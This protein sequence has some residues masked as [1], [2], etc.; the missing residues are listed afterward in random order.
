VI[1]AILAFLLWRP[2]GG[3]SLCDPLTIRPHHSG[4][5]RLFWD[6]YRLDIYLVSDPFHVEVFAP[7]NRS[8]GGLGY[9]RASRPIASTPSFPHLIH[10][11]LTTYVSETWFVRATLLIRDDA[12]SVWGYTVT[13]DCI[14]RILSEASSRTHVSYSKILEL[15]RILRSQP[16]PVIAQH[17]A[18][19]P[20]EFVAHSGFLLRKRVLWAAREEASE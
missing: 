17:G 5:R 12:V 13:R 19:I 1:R 2:N 9:L 15:E 7:H 20:P 4:S 8:P 18:A 3:E 14:T 11:Q 6:V 10:S 16:K